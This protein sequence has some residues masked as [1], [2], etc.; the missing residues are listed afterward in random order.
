VLPRWPVFALVES[1]EGGFLAGAAENEHGVVAVRLDYRAPDSDQRLL[2]QTQPDD[3]RVLDVV[4]V[5]RQVSAPEDDG[6]PVSLSAATATA[7]S[8]QAWASAPALV[9]DQ[10]VP[11]LV[12]RLGAVTAW[13][14]HAFGVLVVVAAWQT[15]VDRPSLTR[16]TD[17]KPFTHHRALIIEQWLSRH[18]LK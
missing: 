14:V 9:D 12:Q 3:G 16:V 18:P 10:P 2:V 1:D 17:L 11:A 7:D 13:Q 8:G 6:T 15:P 4:N 5:S